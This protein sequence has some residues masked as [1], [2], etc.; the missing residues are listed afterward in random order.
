MKDVQ[1]SKSFQNA[2]TGKGAVHLSLEE[3][4]L[5]AEYI[6]DKGVIIADIEVYQ[7]D[8]ETE[9]IRTD[10]S[11][12]PESATRLDWEQKLSGMQVELARFLLQIKMETGE[13]YFNVWL[14]D[15][16]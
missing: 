2:L 9:F 1:M 7:R 4:R 8:G 14:D 15:N 16:I 13:F 12:W 10:L 6:Q 3:L 5:L 11:I